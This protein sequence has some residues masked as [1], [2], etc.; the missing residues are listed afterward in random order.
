ME[1]KLLCCPVT[2]NQ[3]NFR[4]SQSM[5][6]EI[7][8]TIWISLFSNGMSEVFF[9]LSEKII[10]NDTVFITLHAYHRLIENKQNESFIFHHKINVLKIVEDIR[11]FFNYFSS[12]IFAFFQLCLIQRWVVPEETH[13]RV[14]FCTENYIYDEHFL[15]INASVISVTCKSDL[16]F[17]EFRT[18]IYMH[19]A[20]FTILLGEHVRNY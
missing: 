18:I 15:T 17:I 8:K 11:N 20:L 14:V 5:A 9:K 13:S 2:F 6:V 10:L 4:D 7:I 12:D 1:F 16:I 19:V 3:L